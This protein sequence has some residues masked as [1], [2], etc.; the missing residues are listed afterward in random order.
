MMV[1]MQRIKRA[2][3]SKKELVQFLQ[4]REWPDEGKAFFNEDLLPT[5]PGM[6]FADRKIESLAKSSRTKNMECVAFLLLLSDTDLFAK[7]L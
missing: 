5:P 1:S 2:A 6:C 7:F 4:T 3:S